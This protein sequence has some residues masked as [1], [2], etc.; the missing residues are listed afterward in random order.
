[1]RDLVS[2]L[3]ELCLL[4]GP[5]G[6]EDAVRDYILE[7]IRPFAD[8]TVDPLGSII[9]KKAGRARPK[10]NIM[11]DAHMDEVGLIITGATDDGF[12]RFDTLGG[13]LP[14]VLLGRR[15]R[16]GDQIGVIGCVPVHLLSAD[17]R[18]TLPEIGDMAIDIGAASREEA[19]KIVRLGDN[20]VFDSPFLRFGSGMLKGKAI[21]DR[22]G[23]AVLMRLLC[24]DAPFDFT[25]TFTV[26]EENGLVGAK[27]AAYTVAP[28]V[29]LVLE[30]T[31]A[32]DLAGVA[33]E[34]RVCRVGQGPVLSFMDLRTVYDR[35]LYQLAIETAQREAIPFQ[36]KQAVA[37]GNNA[38][39]IHA[40]RG[41]VRTAAIS[42]PC[43]YL[44]SASCVIHEDDLENAAR[45]ARSLLY[46]VAMREEI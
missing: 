17:Q 40:S 20:A 36:T 27:A 34:N 38:G 46:E 31:T 14:Q 10:R 13:I 43:R 23:C 42:L 26:Q 33:Q 8:C 41:G 15:V 2:M 18:D 45:L 21:D 11:L 24:D 28:D 7:R 4:D 39:A 19:L 5:S 29:A 1:M 44:H 12:L 32:A 3:E 16:V 9:A 37:G 22:A 30:S 6:R 35:G 25:A